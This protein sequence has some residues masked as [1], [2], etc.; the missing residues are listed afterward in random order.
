MAPHTQLIICLFDGDAK[1]DEAQ[2][3]IQALDEQLDTIKLGNIAILRKGADG[4]LSFSET[5]ELNEY[6][7]LP[8]LTVPFNRSSYSRLRR[9]ID[10]LNERGDGGRADPAR[11]APEEPSALTPDPDPAP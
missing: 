9:L 10:A 4:Q 11:T 1:A 8:R 2:A 3:A 6:P 5:Q 7:E